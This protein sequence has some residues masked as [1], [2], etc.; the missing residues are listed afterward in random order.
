MPNGSLGDLL[1]H[2]KDDVLFKWNVRCKIAIGAAQVIFVVSFSIIQL[3]LQ[4]LK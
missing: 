2:G 1:H 3:I 4:F